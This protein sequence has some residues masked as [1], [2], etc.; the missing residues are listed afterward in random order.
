M[1]DGVSENLPD[2]FKGIYE[3]LYNRVDDKADVIDIK[4]DIE[5]LISKD[6]I[7][8][9]KKIDREVVTKAIKKIKPG[10]GDP[11]YQFSSDCFKVN[12][13]ILNDYLMELIRSFL[14]HGFLPVILLLSTLMPII[15]DRLG[16]I[17]SSANY[18]SV[19]LT[20]II[21]KIID[22]IYIDI[23]GNK[24]GFHKLQFAYQTNVSPI[25]CSWAVIETIN[26]YRRNNSEVFICSM[27]K[28]KAFDLCKF[29]LLF[30]KI[31]KKLNPVFT[32]LL[33]YIYCNQ[34]SQV[35]YDGTISMRYNL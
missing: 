1:I 21:L 6:D 23:Y 20:S 9:I 29:G 31:H 4:N 34:S 18:R 8:E 32:R 22:W 11:N 2:H 19:C 17:N 30:K 27:D 16:S 5:K 26:Y 33:I 28:S 12:S 15:K 3:E 25:T 10:K 35:S 14:I 13:M 7:A 24:L